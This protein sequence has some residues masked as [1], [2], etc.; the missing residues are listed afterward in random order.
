[1][2]KHWL[3]TCFLQLS[4]VSAI[5]NDSLP[6]A[7]LT[8]LPVLD[9]LRFDGIPD[10]PDWQRMPSFAFHV[11]EPVFGAAPVEKTEMRLLYDENYLYVGSKCFYKDPSKIIIRNF[12]RDGWRGDDWLSV[13]IDSRF[14]H[15]TAINFAIYPAGS[16]YDMLISNDAV[17]LGSSP[18]NPSFNA[19]WDARSVITKE[20][21]FFEMKIPLYNLRYKIADDGSAQ[22]A[23][24]VTRWTAYNN[25]LQHS[26]NIPQGI[27]YGFLKPS[28]KQEMKFDN[29]KKH[30]LLLLTPYLA[31]SA[32][33]K[34]PYNE[35]LK[36]I[37]PD[38][39]TRL[40]AGLDA[41]IGLTQ[42]L[43]L[44]ATI[45]PDFG[46]AEADL[47]QLNLSRFGLYLPERRLFFQEQSGL[48]D[49]G[50][51]N[52]TQLFY[53]RR[54]GLSDDGIIPLY[55]GLRLTGQLNNSIDIGVLN[56]Q[57]AQKQFSD[58]VQVPSEN[59]G[60]VRMRNKVLNDKSFIG[61]LFTN[62]NSS[63]ASNYAL[64]TDAVLN[65]SKNNYLKIGVATTQ[66]S[67]SSSKDRVSVT[68]SR[69]AVAWENLEQKGWIPKFGYTY[70]GKDFNPRLG[71]LDRTDFHSLQAEI[72]YGLFASNK[73]QKFAQQ[74]FTVLKASVFKNATT[75]VT[76]SIST[77]SEWR[78]YTAK[79]ASLNAKATYNYEYIKDSLEFG[80]NIVVR[81]GIYRFP[82]FSFLLFPPSAKKIA[83]PVGFGGGGFFGGQQYF[84]SIS[85]NF[86]SAQKVH[87]Q[88]GYDYTYLH[89]APGS[90]N[91]ST[92]IHI[93]R[94]NIT[95]A[96]NLHFS[97]AGN[98]QYNS[99]EQKVFTNFRVRYNFSDGHDLYVV[100]N[101]ESRTDRYING[102][103]SPVT[104]Q[105][106]LL[107][108]YYYTFKLSGATR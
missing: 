100:W 3:F 88:P 26:V 40:T 72:A 104:E 28:L 62:R 58:S 74:K 32:T 14:D 1:M 41:K 15:R 59:F 107:I 42:R 46:Q 13:H 23:V 49:L 34:N 7:P 77:G 6:K 106:Q 56:M 54:I 48:F 53:S 24:S 18:T 92:H 91:S 44:D 83:F 99:T 9:K 76:E 22:M 5:S 86:N 80:N 33:E 29:L 85:P 60:V 101:N 19:V 82:S 51:G 98:I 68:T 57:S 31:A 105:Q 11:L 36:K 50:L 37:T 43:T 52:N 30:K 67:D 75:G 2:P 35:D 73:N 63:I 20:G 21:W 47:Q 10:E 96:P 55:G 16:R 38:N 93:A 66:T 45:N 61:L 65:V 95:Y 90:N 70:S 78:G 17:E 8:V 94:L 71:F 69:I 64:G 87:I 39:N 102:T 4:V 79:G 12:L 108:K 25:E 97:A 81:S 89:F 84:F 103:K 27:A